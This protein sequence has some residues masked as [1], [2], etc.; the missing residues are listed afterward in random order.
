MGEKTR[1]QIHNDL[2]T[3]Y[4]RTD[5]TNCVTDEEIAFREGYICAMMLALDVV[6]YG[7]KIED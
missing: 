4:E 3:E 5:F 1:R 2:V 7:E 6:A